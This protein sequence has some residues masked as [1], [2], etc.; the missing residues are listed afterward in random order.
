MTGW[1]DAW[2]KLLLELIARCDNLHSTLAHLVY[3]AQPT[4]L[5]MIEPVMPARRAAGGRG[6]HT[7]GSLAAWSAAIPQEGILDKESHPIECGAGVLTQCMRNSP[8]LADPTTGL[9]H[10]WPIPSS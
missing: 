4:P 8:R 9:S 1:R 7:C 2:P 10:N 3:L 5:T 6:S